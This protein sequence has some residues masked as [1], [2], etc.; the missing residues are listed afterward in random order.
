MV[1]GGPGRSTTLAQTRVAPTGSVD[2]LAS[3]EKNKRR[4]SFRAPK[5]SRVTLCLRQIG[6]TRYR[7]ACF[8]ADLRRHT[9]EMVNSTQAHA[10][11]RPDKATH[12][13]SYSESRSCFGG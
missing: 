3:V 6:T 9:P 4:K 1:E 10:A 2:L 5:N 7:T 11:L 13:I 12:Q 8:C